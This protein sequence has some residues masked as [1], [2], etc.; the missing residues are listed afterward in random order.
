MN[1]AKAPAMNHN[2]AQKPQLSA[3]I[4]SYNTR[5]MTL[6]CLRALQSELD[7]LTAE[8]WVVDNDSRDG[9]AEAIRA[10]FPDVHLIENPN[11][12][13]FG[14]ANN[15]AMKQ[16][17]GDFL[18]LLNSD[19]FPKPGAVRELLDCAA[20]HPQAGVIGPRLLNE[21]GSLQVS[22]WRLPSPT[23]AWLENLGVSALLPSHPVL[24]D[25]FRWA[26]DEER[27]VE[28][29]AGACLLVRRA[30]YEAVGGFDENFWMYAEESDWQRRMHEAGWTIVFTPSAEVTHLGG[31]SGASESAKISHHFYHSMD[32]Y[33][34]KHHGLSGLISRRI[35]MSVGSLGRA[36]AFGLLLWLVPR[37][38]SRHSWRA[39]LKLHAGLVKR[40][41]TQWDVARGR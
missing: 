38:Q 40:Q 1:E 21:D 7:G 41:L 36:L 28:F 35:A 20:R 26:H 37:P 17:R 18:L 5:R 22:C 19:A 3:I 23:R 27:E 2:S 25:Y 10:A 24:G 11:N 6:D 4:V 39:K 13:G 15:L 8:I 34:R 29:V 14:A 32:L 12:A 31:A 16:A 33:G 30:V 9:S